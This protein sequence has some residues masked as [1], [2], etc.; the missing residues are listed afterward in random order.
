ML[1]VRSLFVHPMAMRSL[2]SPYPAAC[3]RVTA[4][5]L[6]NAQLIEALYELTA[7]IEE[8]GDIGGAKRKVMLW[9]Q[10]VQQASCCL[11]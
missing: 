2:P 4:L 11:D 5:D 8:R 1:V 9:E 6:A 3:R 10:Q 7:A